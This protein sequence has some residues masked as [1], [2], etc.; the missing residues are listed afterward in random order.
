MYFPT[1]QLKIGKQGLILSRQ[2]EQSYPSWGLFQSPL[3]SCI[4]TGLGWRSCGTPVAMPPS[5][6]GPRLLSPVQGACGRSDH[7][8]G[9][10]HQ[11]G[12]ESAPSWEP[13]ST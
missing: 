5:S 4:D 12:Q 1:I 6:A 13:I 3:E 11:D 10:Q 9:A 7:F 2:Q 8:V